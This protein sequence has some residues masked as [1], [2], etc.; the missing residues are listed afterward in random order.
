MNPSQPSAQYLH[1]RVNAIVSQLLRRFE[2]VMATA[3]VENTSYTATAIE[4]YQIDVESTALVRAAEDILALTRTL[5]ELWLFG[6]LETLDADAGDVARQR[7]LAED[8]AA[9]AGVLRDKG[10]LPAA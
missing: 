8:V 4:Q 1:S 6:K 5:K 3:T 2:N 10:L 7:Q 9:V